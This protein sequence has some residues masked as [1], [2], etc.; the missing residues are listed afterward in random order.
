MTRRPSWSTVR[1]AGAIGACLL[2]VLLSAAPA[3]AQV[4]DLDGKY[5]VSEFDETA[6][7]G[8]VIPGCVTPWTLEPNKTPSRNDGIVK[9]TTQGDTVTFSRENGKVLLVAT[10][11][12]QDD[13]FT[14]TS[15]T[16]GQKGPKAG[17]STRRRRARSP[18]P[19]GATVRSGDL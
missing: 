19:T 13:S 18:V 4:V 3:R 8:S 9:V 2:P 6:G 10:L 16:P 12:T 11:S 17:A 7:N 1:R 5:Q 14:G 15:G